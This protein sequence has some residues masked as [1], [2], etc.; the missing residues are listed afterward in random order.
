MPND[1]LTDMRFKAEACEL[2]EMRNTVRADLRYLV[3]SNDNL[4]R[5]VLAINEACMNIIQHAYRPQSQ[6]EIQLQISSNQ[7]E[8]VIRIID[9]ADHIDVSTIKSRALEDIRPGGLG[10]HFIRSVMDHVEYNH[11]DT[12]VGNILEMKKYL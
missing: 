3:D 11:Q 7:K 4:D 6:G 2:K 5:I 10:V 8:I 9:S 1:L 12:G